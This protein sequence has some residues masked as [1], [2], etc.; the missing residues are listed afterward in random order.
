MG[1]CKE[2][3]VIIKGDDYKI[4]KVPVFYEDPVS[5]RGDSWS[6]R[7]V[8]SVVNCFRLKCLSSTDQACS[9]SRQLENLNLAGGKVSAIKIDTNFECLHSG[10]GKFTLDS[11]SLLTYEHYC[12]RSLIEAAMPC[13]GQNEILAALRFV[14]N[15]KQARLY[16]NVKLYNL[17]TCF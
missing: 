14:T 3:L 10:I 2:A 11:C 9:E 12:F 15:N 6:A 16:I 8:G 17:N 4:R 5:S 13:Y 1:T 7:R